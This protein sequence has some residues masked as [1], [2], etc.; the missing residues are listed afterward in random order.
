M[1]LSI[2]VVD[3]K[4]GHFTEFLINHTH[5]LGS[6]RIMLCRTM[7]KEISLRSAEIIKCFEIIGPWTDSCNNLHTNHIFAPHSL[8]IALLSFPHPKQKG[9]R[10]YGT[11]NSKRQH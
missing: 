8:H 7:A 9:T 3:D 4:T 6:K 2:L 10:H 11:Q 5:A 1:C